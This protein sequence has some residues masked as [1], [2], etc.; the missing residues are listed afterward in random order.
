M[1]AQEL[2]SARV[3]LLVNIHDIARKISIDHTTGLFYETGLNGMISSEFN[4]SQSK[5]I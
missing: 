2:G 1:I 4:I 5:Y 3:N